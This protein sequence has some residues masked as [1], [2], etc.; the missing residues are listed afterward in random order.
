MGQF[1]PGYLVDMLTAQ[2]SDELGFF[3]WSVASWISKD[4]N[5]SSQ[6]LGQQVED[7][8]GSVNAYNK[9]HNK[10]VISETIFIDFDTTQSEYDYILGTNQLET[11]YGNSYTDMKWKTKTFIDCKRSYSNI[12]C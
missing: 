3:N 9:I 4:R 7:G 2:N 6:N 12:G 5:K 8:N 10:T 1:S 11:K